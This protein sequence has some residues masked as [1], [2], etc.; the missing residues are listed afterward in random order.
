MNIGLEPL[1]NF[2]ESD[3]ED[4]NISEFLYILRLPVIIFIKEN[5]YLY[6][7]D[8]DQSSF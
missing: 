7:S 2:N 4:T 5:E 1:K 3:L 8:N 6:C